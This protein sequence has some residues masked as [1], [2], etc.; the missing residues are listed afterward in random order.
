MKFHLKTKLSLLITLIT[1]LGLN[2]SIHSENTSSKSKLDLQSAINEAVANNPTL[3]NSRE[4]VVETQASIETAGTVF[5][6]QIGSTLSYNRTKD[7]VSSGSP[8]FKGNSYN[9][10]NFDLNISQTLFNAQT[11]S[12][13]SLKNI[14]QDIAEIETEMTLQDL[15]G[16]I[17]K[18]FSRIIY[19]QRHSETL[20]NLNDVMKESLKAVQNRVNIGR[21][22]RIDALQMR[23]QLALLEP[24]IAAAEN[25]IRNATATLIEHMGSPNLIS[26]TIEGQ[27]EA[28]SPE[29]LQS[30]INLAQSKLL[31]LEKLEL[32]KKQVE[33]ERK[34]L[35]SSHW[36]TLK[37][38]G[39]WNR[40]GLTTTELFDSATTRWSAGLALHVPLFSGLSSFY[41]R[42]EM[43]SKQA[44]LRHQ[45]SSLRNRLSLEQIM[46]LENL[47]LAY[48]Q[49]LSN[50]NAQKLAQESQS[51]AKRQYRL[52]T[53]E[54]AQLL[55]IQKD[56]LEASVALEE[57]RIKYVESLVD[58]FIS[59]GLPMDT[60]VSILNQKGSR[61]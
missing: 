6:P 4:R 14:D 8:R 58:Y 22:D 17:A 10:Y 35:N 20:N 45:E 44:Q 41:Q 36:P 21:S 55:N 30:K 60:L 7:A 37:A 23:T 59:T 54:L 1:G 26:I 16:Q 3:K 33:A 25:G 19:W 34:S 18:S 29:N 61:P 31:Q 13:L 28:P 53:I 48:L 56:V 15:K 52:S 5:W 2:N 49:I 40:Q 24:R 12:G 46:S 50:Q 39:N 57:A 9:N 38:E 47:K 51:E 11:F 42:H 32:Q 27:L 43:A